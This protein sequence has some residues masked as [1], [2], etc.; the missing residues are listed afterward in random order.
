MNR[1]ELVALKMLCTHYEVDMS[2]FSRL[3]ELDLIE[4]H[5]REQVDYVHRDKVGEIERMIRLHVELDINHEGIDTIFNLL[6]KIDR[7][8][9]E[10]ISMKN[11][12]RRYGADL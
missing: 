8:E 12:L 1:N 10:V 6:D 11:K 7:L 5:T 3:H 4:I 9:S 2:F